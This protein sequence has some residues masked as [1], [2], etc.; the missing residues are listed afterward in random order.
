MRRRRV[1]FMPP[2][3]RGLRAIAPRYGDSRF[4]TSAG[5]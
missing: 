1:N 2:P 5:E 4:A 3:L